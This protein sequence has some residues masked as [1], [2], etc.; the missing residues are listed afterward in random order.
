VVINEMR[1]ERDDMLAQVNGALYDRII[2]QTRSEFE[3]ALVTRDRKIAELEAELHECKGFIGG[4]V[5]MLSTKALTHDSRIQNV[6]VIDE[7][8]KGFLRRVHHG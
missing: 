8:P 5:A 7:L 3:A 4:V 1:E 2:D 6:E